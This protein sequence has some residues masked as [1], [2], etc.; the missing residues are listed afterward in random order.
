VL[1]KSMTL[2]EAASGAIN[3]LLDIASGSLTFGEIVG[4]GSEVVSRLGPSM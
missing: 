1:R 3:R 2:E 4:E